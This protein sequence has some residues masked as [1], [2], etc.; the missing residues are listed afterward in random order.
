[1]METPLTENL[2]SK[3]K[4]ITASQVPLEGKLAR[5]KDIATVVLFLCSSDSDYISGENLIVSGGYDMH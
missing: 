1:M 2:P 5:P 3:L 4:E